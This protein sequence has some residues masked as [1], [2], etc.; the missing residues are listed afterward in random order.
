MSEQK[1]PQVQTLIN[2]I[3]KYDL[4][5]E[6]I[7]P[8]RI[9]SD[10]I[11]DEEVKMIYQDQEFIVPVD[12]E[13][14]DV[15]LNNPAVFLNMIL[16]EV[17]HFEESEDIYEWLTYVTT[18]AKDPEIVEFYN[19]LSSVVPKIRAIVGNEIEPIPHFEIELNTG[20]AQALRT[21][22]FKL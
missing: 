6:V 3:K 1:Y 5:F 21:A 11:Y 19:R 12:N 15:E 10:I 22:I 9:S 2:C 17:T 8:C 7:T 20:M 14:E 13:Y 16:D 18:L 4:K